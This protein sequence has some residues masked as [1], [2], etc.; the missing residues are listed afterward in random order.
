[1]K[2]NFWFIVLFLSLVSCVEEAQLIFTESNQLYKGNATIEINIP[3]AQGDTEL[4]NNINLKIENHIA[5]TLIFSEEDSNTATLEE[6]ISKFDAEYKNFKSDF[7][8]SKLIWEATFDGE[9]MYQTSEVISI[10]ISSYI[11]T[12][13]AH[14]NS[15]LTFYNFDTLN[16]EILEVEDFINNIDAFTKI[17]EQHFIEDVD[18]DESETIA[19][20]F[21]GESFHLPANIGF[22]EEGLVLLYNTYEVASYA[23]GITEFT[24]PFED[25]DSLLIKQ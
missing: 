21:F 13:G 1:M 3:I 22:N 8:E 16:R 19:D 23:M 7:E 6:G 5:N 10:A 17:A 12:G 14:G 2:H 25:I 4:A 9:V 15:V 24:I 20:Y 11:N 18:L